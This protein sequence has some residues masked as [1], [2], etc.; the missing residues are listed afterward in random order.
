MVAINSNEIFKQKRHALEGHVYSNRLEIDISNFYINF[1]HIIYQRMAAFIMEIINKTSN[2]L[3]I[4]YIYKYNEYI[5][6]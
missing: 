4:I 1:S 2:I 5:K 3:V 6:H